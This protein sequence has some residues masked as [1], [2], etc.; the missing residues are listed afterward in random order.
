MRK[1][2]IVTD[3][4]IRYRMCV[5][6][7]FCG[8]ISWFIG[9]WIPF[10]IT[11]PESDSRIT[12]ALDPGLIVFLLGVVPKDDGWVIEVLDASLIGLFIGGLYVIFAGRLSHEEITTARRLRRIMSGALGGCL[13]GGVGNVLSFRPRFLWL[14][15]WPRGGNLLAW[16]LTGAGIGLVIGL[17]SYRWFLR[18]VLLA[19]AGSLVGAGIGGGLLILGGEVVP[20]FRSLGLSLTGLSIC[21]CSTLAVRIG[22]RAT[23]KFINSSDAAA[24][25]GLSGREVDLLQNIKY[26][27]GRDHARESFGHETLYIRVSDSVMAP[28]HAMIRWRSGAFQLSACDENLRAGKPIRNLEAG[29]PPKIVEGEYPLQNEDEIIMGQ[30]RF[31]FQLRKNATAALLCLLAGALIESAALAQTDEVR[32]ALPERIQMLRVHNLSETVV[33]RVPLNIVTATGKP[34]K[35]SA[36]NP[37]HIERGI[38]VF[39][40]DSELR[41]CHIGLG[42]RPR[43]YAILLVDVS[44]SMLEPAEDGSRKFDAMKGAC[45]RFVED[46]VPGVDFIAVVPFHSHGVIENIQRAEFFT[47]KEQLRG[48]I[49]QLPAP[50]PENNTALY[51]AAQAALNRLMQ[52]QKAQGPNAQ[53][54]LVLLTDGKNDVRAGDDPN[55]ETSPDNMIALKSR[56]D[57]PIITVGFGN[58]RNL[59][60]ND[61]RNLASPMISGYYPARHADDLVAAFQQARSV[62]LDRLWVTF[63]PR[64]NSLTQLV[65]PHTYRIQLVLDKGKPAEGLITW[66]PGAVNVPQGVLPAEESDCLP[67]QPRPDWLQ[68]ILIFASL[69][70]FLS[71][72]WF[73][74]P[75]W[76]RRSWEDEKVQMVWLPH[77]LELKKWL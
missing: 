54:L 28:R 6:G 3:E 57:I 13:A 76:I 67:P 19:A 36:Y 50:M 18:Y 59:N 8:L 15:E 56:A 31:V 68:P 41:V 37:E 55:L 73:K 17:I 14:N 1:R 2:R 30:T 20:H 58:N 60:E 39:E 63:L 49:N 66:T 51:S 35:I 26:V 71:L 10:L 9:V 32:L 74:P 25:D 22:R 7:A 69:S 43:R 72:M 75:K 24:G 64:P 23:L 44:G 40:G 48:Y 46:F 47:D 61:L 12:S 38:H 53:Y 34:Q 11:L 45:L 33:F 27:F 29:S 62:Q 65:S 77:I 4:E 52:I 42:S 70:L 5:A 16:C 21:F